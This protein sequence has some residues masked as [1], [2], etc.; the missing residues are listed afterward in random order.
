MK[1][2]AK[3]VTI[4]SILYSP[5]LWAQSASLA[6][7]VVI[8]YSSIGMGHLSA[9]RAIEASIRQKDPNA[10][11]VLKN[12]RDFEPKLKGKAGESVYWYLVK[13]H[14]DAFDSMFRKKMAKGNAV[15]H[16][17]SLDIGS[18]DV[19]AVASYLRLQGPS[20]V[21]ATHYGAAQVLAKLRGEGHLKTTPVAWLHTDYFQGYFPRISKSIDMTFVGMEQVRQQ[22]L[23][24]GV[25][26]NAVVSSGIPVNPAVF[27]PVDREAFLKSK[28][29]DP[30]VKTVVIA[31]GGEGVGD[32]QNLVSSIASAVGGPIQIVAAC[33]KS[34]KNYANLEKL[35]SG[36]RAGV[37]LQVHKMIPQTDLLS[38]I[39]AADVYITKSGG[40]SPTEGFA[41]IKPIVLLDI[42]GGHERDNAKLFEEHKLALVNNDENRVGADVQRLLSD[43]KLRAEMLQAQLGFRN[44]L[45]LDA[46]GDYVVNSAGKEAFSNYYLGVEGGQPARATEN[47]LMELE[48]ASPADIEI[49]LSYPASTTGRM[50]DSENPFGHIAVR[51]GDTVY[52]ANHLAQVGQE[53]EMMLGT[54]LNEYLYSVNRT[55]TNAE[56]TSS[57]GLAYGRDSISLRV[58][59]FT[60]DQLARF[61][62]GARQIN[63]EWNGGRLSWNLRKDNCAALSMRILQAGGVDFPELEKLKHG[64]ALP[65]EV[66]DAFKSH[67]E[68]RQNL[69]S[70]VVVYSQVEGSQSG[71]KTTRFP[72]S[73]RQVR[74]SIMNLITNRLD[75][76]ER[77]A[78]KRIAFYS[79]DGRAYFENLNGRSVEQQAAEIA[80]FESE[81]RS[82][83]DQLNRLETT[84]D[85][86]R[87]ELVAAGQT[88]ARLDATVKQELKS[89]SPASS[90]LLLSNQF[91]DIA[92]PRERQIASA[93]LETVRRWDA[94]QVKYQTLNDQVAQMELDYF[95]DGAMQALRVSEQAMAGVASAQKVK[96][97]QLFNKAEGHYSTF[98]RNRFQ[99][100]QPKDGPARTSPYRRFFAAVKEYMD[101]FKAEPVSRSPRIAAFSE[102]LR[103]RAKRVFDIISVIVRLT[104]RAA[105]TLISL[106]ARPVS[107]IG[108]APVN[109]NIFA[110]LRDL[111][112]QMRVSV[113]IQGKEKLPKPRALT[114]KTINIVVPT[115]RD[116]I[117][118]ALV[119]ANL[120]LEKA[121][122]VLAP[123]QFMPRAA[124][125][126]FDRADSTIAVGRGKNHATE[127]ILEQVARGKSDTILIYPEGSVPAGLQEMR[128]PREKFSWLVEKLL[129]DGY[130]VNLIPVTYENTAQ[131]A[132]EAQRINIFSP[133]TDGT[134]LRAKVHDKVDSVMLR[135]LLASSGTQAIGRY[136]RAIWMDGLGTDD[137]S[138]HGLLRAS[139]ATEE[140]QKKVGLSFPTR[141]CRDLFGRAAGF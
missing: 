17:G 98:K 61:K 4:V 93:L 43:E 45:S 102:G 36:L 75:P 122:L 22:W 97:K 76:V 111:Q 24:Q 8:F 57:F 59:G 15:N 49:I 134:R 50:L 115:H 64:T 133:R 23:N 101:V 13:N 77:Q 91:G 113:E 31:T 7:K 103:T 117:L 100:G 41:I 73:F 121:L 37:Q 141:E 83:L 40:L 80:R 33:A 51:V 66:F 5:A 109:E 130:D 86:R 2:I 35:K 88:A 67:F 138:L 16:L 29:L 46:I 99:Y 19:A 6:K 72:L 11:V 136:I 104:P 89:L 105:A 47:A 85:M 139:A 1:T 63:N 118:D 123:D 132:H 42:Y 69:R 135:T 108:E 96:L 124:A 32:F 20:A 70:E 78:G 25:D 129:R 74:R 48:A 94:A 81:Q 3:V 106:L 107:A 53:K 68:S 137:R 39:K 60:S 110:F 28:G 95:I 56:H 9:S 18:Y 26:P 120:G 27:T 10:V 30:N 90:A 92:D 82:V 52:T 112:A 21:V 131:F 140:F 65:L 54:S 12:I 58:K 14:P 114:G 128:P 34:E 119:M 116:A 84:I 127:Q 44:S 125:T 55:N 87:A 62:E 79:G 126:L 38:Y 71:L